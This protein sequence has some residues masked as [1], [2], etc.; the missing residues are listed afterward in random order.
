[1]NYKLTKT[2]N[3]FKIECQIRHNGRKFRKQETF[4]GS[5]RSANKRA[6]QIVNELNER[7]TEEE[8]SGS[9]K[10]FGECA[11]F[12]RNCG[13]KMA[14]SNKSYF[15]RLENDLGIKRVDEMGFAFGRFLELLRSSTTRRGKQY[16]P[17]SINHYIK[18]AKTIL[19][20]AYTKNMIEENPLVGY[21]N[22]KISPREISFSGKDKERVLEVTKKLTPYL[23]PFLQYVFAV[24]CRKGELV[25]APREAYD[26][27]NNVIRLKGSTTKSGKSV[28]KPVPPDMVEYFRSIPEECPYLFYRKDKGV[29]KPLGDF[30][31]AWSNIRI[32]AGVPE[33]RVHDTRHISATNLHNAGLSEREVMEVAG[34]KTPM[35]STYYEHGGLST[36]RKAEALLSSSKL[37]EQ[38]DCG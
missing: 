22:V 30:K 2:D 36:I 5:N 26:Q 29:F 28:T 37:F 13:G 16:S 38:R 23:V 34:W 7:I 9:L 27:F 19:N 20:F 31:R 12:Y 8:L 4:I 17:H 3:G 32:E 11:T 33:F 10:T 1:M 25:K 18:T 35:L 21:K 6:V 24:P 15:K 14:E